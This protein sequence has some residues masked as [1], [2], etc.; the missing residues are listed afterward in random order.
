MG[1]KLAFNLK[2]FSLKAI[3]YGN[4]KRRDSKKIKRKLLLVRLD[5]L[6]NICRKKNS[7]TN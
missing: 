3:P 2:V 1:K 4:Q 5:N 7:R 6:A